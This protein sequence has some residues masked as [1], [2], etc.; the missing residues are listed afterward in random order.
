MNNKGSIE[1][2]LVLCCLVGVVTFLCF[3][4]GAINLGYGVEQGNNTDPS[5]LGKERDELL[6]AKRQKEE[7]LKKLLEQIAELKTTIIELEKKL[8]S[9]NIPG[10]E[11]ER[12][13]KEEYL[14]TLNEQLEKLA[15]QIE[16]KKK[17]LA[18]AKLNLNDLDD[19]K[20]MVAEI[21]KLEERLN[22]LERQLKEK[23]GEYSNLL[24][25]LNEIDSMGK[26]RTKLEESIKV[27]K[28]EK[29]ELIVEI[30]NSED[31]GGTSIFNNALYVECRDNHIVLYPGKKTI[32]MG[33]LEEYNQIISNSSGHDG[34]VFY[35]RPDGFEIF[36]KVFQQA[37][38]AN[39]RLAYVPLEAY[40]DIPSLRR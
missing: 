4:M 16:E 25:S 30:E 13:D 19:K 23:S 36:R 35:V 37:K 31:G 2:L 5:L 34:I 39:L 21:E 20:R 8:A 9:M 40:K 14:K 32:N 26:N 38:D 3:A 22:A 6:A 7:E 11:T 15:K 17:L 10:I 29:E 28:R 1:I 12:K 18:N 27:A 24:A 33:V